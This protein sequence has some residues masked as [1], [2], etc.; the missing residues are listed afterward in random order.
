MTNE[1]IIKRSIFQALQKMNGGELP[2][3]LD[4]FLIQL[5]NI[6]SSKK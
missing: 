5:E 4:E 3:G 1:E 6:E 2:I